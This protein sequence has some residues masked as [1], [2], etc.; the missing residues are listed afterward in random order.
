MIGLPKVDE[1][2]TCGP[3][4]FCPRGPY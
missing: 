1:C 4:K 3:D 2:S